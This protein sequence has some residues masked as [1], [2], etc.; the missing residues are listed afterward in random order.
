MKKLKAAPTLITSLS[1]YI[2]Q[3]EKMLQLP[4]NIIEVT[5]A[6]IAS[7][8]ALRRTHGL[9]VND[10]VNLACAERLS[11]TN[12]V[13]HDDDFTRIPTISVWEPTDI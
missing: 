1:D 8:H 10:S 6:D 4:F 11:I 12:I 13:T 5:A 2:T 9:F 3:V 7:S